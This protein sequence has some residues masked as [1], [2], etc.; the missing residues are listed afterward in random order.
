MNVYS[1]RAQRARWEAA[2]METILDTTKPCPHCNVKTERNG[3]N[4]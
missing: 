3:K 4:H 1:E 2:S